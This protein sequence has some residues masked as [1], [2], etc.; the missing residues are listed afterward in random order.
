MKCPKCH[1]TISKKATKCRY[2]TTLLVKEE[3]EIL[4]ELPL[5]KIAKEIPLVVKKGKAKIKI[6]RYKWEKY[7]K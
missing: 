2:C 7:E 4:E 3:I 6:K 1:K 5:P